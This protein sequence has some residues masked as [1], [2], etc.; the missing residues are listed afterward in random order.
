MVSLFHHRCRNFDLSRRHYRYLARVFPD[1]LHTDRICDDLPRM[2]EVAFQ[3]QTQ[4]IWR[5]TGYSLHWANHVTSGVRAAQELGLGRYVVRYE[6]MVDEPIGELSR[7][8]SALFGV[9]ADLKRI[10]LAVAL[11][12]PLRTG[13]ATLAGGRSFFRKGVTKEWKDVFTR[14]AG[15]VF[16]RYGNRPLL[17][18]G[19]ES[20]PDWWRYLR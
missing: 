8:H 14:E 11:H 9:E 13:P 20:D 19:Y 5:G 16:S 2:I 17:E 12:D 6:D 7:I 4:R 3:G 1:G 10:E 15:E 18:L